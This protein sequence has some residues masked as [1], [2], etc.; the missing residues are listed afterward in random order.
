MN[1]DNWKTKGEAAAFLGRSEKHIERAVQRGKL[2]QAKRSVAGG[3]T[4]SV[5]NPDDLEE[6]RGEQ[7][8]ADSPTGKAFLIPAGSSA[9]ESARPA[10]PAVLRP[11]FASQFAALAAA[12]QPPAKT[13]YVPLKEAA[14]LSGLSRPSVRELGASGAVRTMRT[15]G[16]LVYRRVDLERL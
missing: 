11:D 9:G 12:F 8:M 2:H 16:G 14:A 15:R 13:T 10:P 6:L 7:D 5:F 1:L 3:R 4:V